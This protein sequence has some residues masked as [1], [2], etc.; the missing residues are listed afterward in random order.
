M[1]SLLG[2]TLG[3]ESFWKEQS[4]SKCGTVNGNLGKRLESSV[5]KELKIAHHP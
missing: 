1:Q 5:F 2:N 4:S 3:E